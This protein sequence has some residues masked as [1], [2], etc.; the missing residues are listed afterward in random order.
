MDRMNNDRHAGTPGGQS[1]E[2]TGL[3]AVGVDDLGF[4]ELNAAG[5]IDESAQIKPGLDRADERGNQV[6][7]ERAGGC[8]GFEGTFRTRGGT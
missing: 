4:E 8:P 6:E 1:P 2:E 5:Q 3:T 7:R